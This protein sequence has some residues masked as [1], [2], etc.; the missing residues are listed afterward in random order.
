MPTSL[1]INGFGRIGRLVFRAAVA[2]PEVVVKAVNDPF[3][4]LKYMVYQLQYDS[5]HGRFN[6][7]IAIKEDGGKEYLV[8][9]G[10][11]VRVFH[12]KDPASIGW[13]E[14]G[15]EYVCE[16]TGV[17]TAQ[18]KAELHIKGGAKKVI[19]SAPPKDAVPIYVVGV[20]HK[21]YK[22]TDT[23]VSNASCTTNCLAPITKVVHEKFGI[24][25]GLMTTVHAMTATQLTVDGPSRGGK[26]WRGGRCASQNIIPSSTGAAKAV[27]KVLPSVN[28]K[29]T[30]MAFRV[31][32]PDVSVVDLTCRLEK[33]A[34]YEEI[35][36]AIKEAAAGDMKGVL[37]WTEDE[38]VS[39]DFTTCKASS[40]FDV[41]AGIALNDHFVKLVTWY[42]NEWGYSNRLVELAIYMKSIDG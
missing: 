7:T 11:D 37:D 42:D 36:A 38:V 15:A 21:D 32:T 24:I 2:N 9:N 31:P 20:N 10:T 14:S 29:L 13:G 8:V 12:E 1:G 41:K 23:V 39:T 4:E 40:I 34:K 19:I 25:E 27:G 5:V 26:D 18:E 3:M 17:F 22:A 6:G 30:G 28:G 16:S 33:P 35:V